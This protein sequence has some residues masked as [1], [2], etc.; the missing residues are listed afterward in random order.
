[1]VILFYTNKYF[2][3]YSS[4]KVESKNISSVPGVELLRPPIKS[5]ESLSS[6]GGYEK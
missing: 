3:D 4:Y 2:T 5:F 6:G 1:M